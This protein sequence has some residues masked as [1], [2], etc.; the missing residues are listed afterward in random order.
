MRA[1][2]S[3]GF[4][5]WDGETAEALLQRCDEALYAAKEAG[6]DCVQLASG[7]GPSLRA[8]A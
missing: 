3:I 5:V 4:A 2:L 6:R 7:S 8:V 1:S